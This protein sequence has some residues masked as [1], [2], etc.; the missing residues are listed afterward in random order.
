MKISSPGKNGQGLV[1]RIA[2][3]IRSQSNGVA[4]GYQLAEQLRENGIEAEYADETHAVLMFSASS[5]EEDFSKT[6]VSR[7]A[8]KASLGDIALTASVISI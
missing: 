2:A 5:A 7:S 4:T 1:S 6:F 3:H 8:K